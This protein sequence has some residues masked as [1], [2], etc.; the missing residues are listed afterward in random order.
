[1]QTPVARPPRGC[2][3][4]ANTRNVRST[5]APRIRLPQS[6]KSGQSPRAK[7]DVG[8]APRGDDVGAQARCARRLSEPR[9]RGAARL[10][11]PLAR[12]APSAPSSELRRV[13]RREL[14]AAVRDGVFSWFHEPPKSRRKPNVAAF[15]RTGLCPAFLGGPW[16]S[17]GR[18]TCQPGSATPLVSTE[19]SRGLPGQACG[20]GRSAAA[21]RG[22]SGPCAPAGAARRRPGWGERRA[23][24]SAAAGGG[25]GSGHPDRGSA[26]ARAHV[27]TWRVR[28]H[29]R[30]GRARV[31]V[32]H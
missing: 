6:L 28:M 29:E 4:P 15:L 18:C 8:G 24:S 21:L 11:A 27:C 12:G 31:S 14:F 17:T 7:W 26:R 10:P 3:G 25:R 1:M 5:Q 16:V 9:G 13:R 32:H 30:A 22:P 19:C 23:G 20:S 2:L